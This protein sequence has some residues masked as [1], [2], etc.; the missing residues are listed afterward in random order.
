[1]LNLFKYM[2]TRHAYY[3]CG[4]TVIINGKWF[5]ETNKHV[6]SCED[7]PTVII[8]YITKCKHMQF[9]DDPDY[10]FTWN[11]KKGFYSVNK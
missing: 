8:Y 6:P 10:I 9:D 7:D 11:K 3:I 5:D 2:T 4:D 1:M